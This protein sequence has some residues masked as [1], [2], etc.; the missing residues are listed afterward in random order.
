[1][2][3]ASDRELSSV[4]QDVGDELAFQIVMNPSLRD[5]VER[6]ARGRATAPRAAGRARAAIALDRRAASARLASRMAG[7]RPRSR[8]RPLRATGSAGKP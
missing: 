8:R 4:L 2:L 1:M 7:A 3:N 5:D 6:R